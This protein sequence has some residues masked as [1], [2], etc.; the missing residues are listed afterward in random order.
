MHPSARISCCAAVMS[1]GIVLA[2]A[3]GAVPDLASRRTVDAM[4]VFAD[5]RRLDLFYYAPLDIRLVTAPDG[6][7]DF[8]FVEMRYT[9]SARNRDR[10]L[11]LH[12][13]LLTLRV[14]LPSRSTD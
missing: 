2:A 4:A 12:K 10:G 11:I 14:Q 3:A 13:S 5:D 6:R 1:W 9:G 8:S 7:P